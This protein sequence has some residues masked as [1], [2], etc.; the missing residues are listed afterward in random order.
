M[1]SCRPVVTFAAFVSPS[2]SGA[3]YRLFG[4]SPHPSPTAARLLFQEAPQLACP[5]RALQLPKRLGLDLADALTRD[6]EHL[7]DLLEGGLDV[8]RLAQRV[9]RRADSTPIGTLTC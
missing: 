5:G 1:P 2:R 8:D 9:E 7:A 6:G 4:R 3:L